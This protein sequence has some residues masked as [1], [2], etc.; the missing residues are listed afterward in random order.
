VKKTHETLT[1]VSPKW[2]EAKALNTA[3]G[4]YRGG[5]WP[6]VADPR[7][8]ERVAGWQEEEQLLKG[9]IAL[10]HMRAETRN[11]HRKER[12]RVVFGRPLLLSL[13]VIDN[14][15]TQVV[16]DACLAPVLRDVNMIIKSQEFMDAVKQALGDNKNK[17]L[18]HWLRAVGAN[19]KNNG[20]ANGTLDRLAGRARMGAVAMGLGANISGGLIQITGY[21]PLASKL[22]PFRTAR[23]ILRGMAYPIE[24]KNEVLAKSEFMREQLKGQDR[25]L[26]E[27]TLR[28]SA[29]GRG[30]LDAVRGM[31]MAQYGLFQNMCNIPGWYE[32]YKKG[33]GDFGGD[34]V[35]AVR[36]ADMIIRTTQSA[37]SIADLTQIETSGTLGRMFTM[38][39]SWF[40]VQANLNKEF[41]RRL[42]HEEGGLHK[43]GLFLNWSLFVL[44]MPRLIERLIRTGGPD[45]EDTWPRWLARESAIGLSLA[46]FESVPVV[47][48]VT[49]GVIS[50]LSSGR[51]QYG[52]YRMT[53]I[54]NAI[55]SAY[56][57]VTNAADAVDDVFEGEETDWGK[58]ARDFANFGGYV[59]AMPVTQAMKWYDAA[60][61]AIN[62]ED[63]FFN[64][65][66]RIV[67]GRRKEKK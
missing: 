21:I 20:L 5:Y 6:A 31:M 52:G 4:L 34:E 53:P 37:A 24:V 28:W 14:H 66:Y 35:K 23:A 30:K 19:N 22:G 42:R 59:A 47:R 11:S 39:Y 55:D 57:L 7:Y 8:N 12:S 54:S 43:L 32:A 9:T 67:L 40:R 36:Y 33:L 26:R 2:V 38:F 15:L 29:R 62:D 60:S 27:M 64:G 51:R 44:M 58:V 16:H 61:D 50:R 1:G 63:T 17:L 13:G 65:A 46:P 10:D 25:D 49:A 56:N 18:N 45:E 41:F 3:H 48:D